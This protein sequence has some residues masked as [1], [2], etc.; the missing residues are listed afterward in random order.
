MF[1][2]RKAENG[3]AKSISQATDMKVDKNRYIIC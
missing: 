2:K 3:S 1:K